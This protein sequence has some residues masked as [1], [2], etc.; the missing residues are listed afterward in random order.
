MYQSC[1]GSVLGLSVGHLYC[2]RSSVSF[3][4]LLLLLPFSAMTPTVLCCE[5]HHRR[6]YHAYLKP[7]ADGERA[8]FVAVTVTVAGTVNV[9]SLS[10]AVFVA[11]RQALAELPYHHLQMPQ[12]QCHRSRPAPLP[13]AGCHVP[14][15]CC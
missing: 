8:V 15:T 9:S 14:L 5:P 10:V 2:D 6:W 3:C 4:T 11:A 12:S 1:K 7:T 13:D